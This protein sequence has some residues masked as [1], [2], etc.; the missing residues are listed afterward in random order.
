MAKKI[1]RPTNNEVALRKESVQHKTL[2]QEIIEGV[3]DSD[4]DRLQVREM[5]F[6]RLVAEEGYNQTDAYKA[7]FDPAGNAKPESI[8][9]LA[10][11][12]AGRPRVRSEIERI[13]AYLQEKAVER[14][15]SLSWA[16]DGPQVRDRIAL[17]MACIACHPDAPFSIRIKAAE[18]LG[19]MKHVDAFI[20]SS[21][22][23]PDQKQ[24]KNLLGDIKADDPASEA[25]RKLLDTLNTIKNSRIG[26]VAIDVTAGKDE[27]PLTVITIPERKDD[28]N[29]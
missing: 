12:V 3:E 19:N 7:T 24:E 9:Q 4:R 27:E 15:L 25:K 26:K 6:A 5:A 1:G 13:R 21:A 11:R 8:R 16:L 17:E 29:I 14:D 28:G 22:T 18:V 20:R 2:V 10:C 23:G